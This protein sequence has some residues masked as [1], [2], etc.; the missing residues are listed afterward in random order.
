MIAAM[1]LIVFAP[2][3][4]EAFYA[5]GNERALRA[6]GAV[7]PPDDVYRVMQVA[8]PACFLAMIAEGAM[9]SVRADA[10]FWAGAA[11]FAA[12]KGLKYWAIATLGARW[13]F[14]VLVPPGSHR[15]RRGPYRWLAHPNYAGVAA[16]LLGTALAMH[17]IVSGPL[18]V[19]GFGFLILRRIAVE[20]SALRGGGVG[21]RR[22]DVSERS[23]AN[24][25][26]GAQRE[27][28]ATLREPQ[29]RPELS[30][31]ASERAGESEGRSPSGTR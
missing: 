10:L 26:N 2:M 12:G 25:A 24:H 18:A 20:E 29:G 21:S 5:A 13:T 27:A 17:A 22:Y 3:I 23:E 6:G 9:R 11:V 14:R 7:E 28:P 8:Y 15:I 16:E 19:A 30:R 4:G 31:R 1:F